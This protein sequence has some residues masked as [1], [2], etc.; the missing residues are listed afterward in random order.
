[1]SKKVL[2]DIGAFPTDSIPLSIN[3]QY[4]EGQGTSLDLS[5]GTWTGEAACEQL[6]VT[7]QPSNIGSG[8][9]TIVTETAIA[10]YDFVAEDFATVGIFELIIWIGNGANREGSKVFRYE[11]FD[12][13]GSAPIV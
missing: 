8:S 2:I 13:P 5:T 7:D 3:Y 9:V 12:A 11:V 6:Y 10:T 4:K 1:M